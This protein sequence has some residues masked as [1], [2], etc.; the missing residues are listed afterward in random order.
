MK[1]KIINDNKFITRDYLERLDNELEMI[2]VTFDPVFKSVFSSNINLL[3]RFLNVVLELDLDIDEMEIKLLNSEL[4][5]EN[6][7]EYQKRIDIYVC[8]NG[9]MYI[10]IEINRSNFNRVK[11]RNY[12]YSSKA[13]SM[14]LETGNKISEL[15]DKYFCQ[16]NLN[17][18]DKSIDY[19]EDIIVR[20]SLTRENIYMDQDKIVLKFLEYYR[21][22]YYT[23]KNELDEAGIWLAGLTSTTFSELYDIFSNILDGNELNVFI[24][25]VIKMSKDYF[26]IHEWEKE[27]MDALVK[28]NYYK[29]G[30]DEGFYDGLEQGI[31][32]GILEGIQENTLNMIKEM[33]KNK[34]DIETI[35]K[36]TKLSQEEIERIEESMKN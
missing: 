28:Y 21:K 3:K 17:T 9:N 22:L 23:D 13:Y 18:E 29:D 2:P 5:R 4:P 27:K 10:D 24:G 36:V 33:I 25:D 35:S 7:C 26:S 12:L 34:I 31:E 15:E 32:Q 1:Y 6:I 20:Y 8:I 30:K 19:G 11:L 16:L 14:F